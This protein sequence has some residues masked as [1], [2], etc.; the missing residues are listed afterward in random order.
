LLR[1][2]NKIIAKAK[3]K[4]RGNFYTFSYKVKGNF[5]SKTPLIPT[6]WGR[7]GIKIKLSEIKC[8]VLRIK[9]LG[10]RRGAKKKGQFYGL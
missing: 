4:N 5:F 9:A 8:T 3:E 2:S 10:L 1:T 7:N 6:L